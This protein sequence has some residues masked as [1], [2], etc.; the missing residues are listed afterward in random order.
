MNFRSIASITNQKPARAYQNPFQASGGV[1]H[2]DLSIPT[3][4]QVLFGARK[5]FSNPDEKQIN[6]K[7]Q[8]QQG[9]WR[10]VLAA[11]KQRQIEVGE[12]LRQSLPHLAMDAPKKLAINQVVDILKGNH[13]GKIV[14]TQVKTLLGP[15]Q[16]FDEWLSCLKKTRKYAQIS[17][18]NFENEKVAGGR[19]SDGADISS[20]WVKQQQI[21]NLIEKKASQGVRFQILLD[22]SVIRARDEFNNPVFPRKLTNEEMIEH[23]KKLKEEKGLPIEVVAYPRSVA[24]IYHVKL[25]ISDGKRAIV[26]GMNLSNHSAANWDACVS[27][28]GPEVANIQHDTFHPDWMF[29]RHREDRVLTKEQLAA[30]LPEINPVSKPALKV[31]NTVPRE[32]REIGLKGK[33]EIGD[34][35]KAKVSDPKLQSLH[36]EQFIATHK[37]IKDTLIQRHGEGVNVKVLHSSSVVDAFPYSRKAIFDMMRKGVP[38]RFYNE[39][40]EIGQKLHSK[41]TVFNKNEVMIGSANLSARGLETNLQKGLRDDYPNYPNQRYVRG[42]RDMAIVIPKSSKIAGAFLKQ[43]EL[44]WDFS[45]LKY[46]SGYGEFEKASNFTK[47]MEVAK[48]IVRA[49]K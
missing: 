18:Y 15:D 23:F 16:I 17:M 14:K 12:F 20:A 13:N 43:F 10:R 24:H 21:L 47:F 27:I 29:A 28:E 38:I 26:G 31:L 5:G 41:W 11:A 3:F 2:S 1:K 19:T 46:P 44:D 45:P 6:V 9:F 37:E 32:Y 48:K 39:W 40:E 30:E 22:N 42:N 34:Y 49:L 7:L 33:E 4:D 8:V 36:S 35:I 25:L